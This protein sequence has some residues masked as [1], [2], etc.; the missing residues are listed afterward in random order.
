MRES[1]PLY[2]HSLSK[3]R[4]CVDTNALWERA[5][6]RVVSENEPAPL[7]STRASWLYGFHSSRVPD[8]M[9]AQS[10]LAERRIIPGPLGV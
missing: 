10:R 9:P 1:N 4:T 3:G 5:G 7:I 2:Q 8:D 6:V